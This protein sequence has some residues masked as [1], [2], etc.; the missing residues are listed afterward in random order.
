[1]DGK[2]TPQLTVWRKLHLE[3]DKMKKPEGDKRIASVVGSE[4]ASDSGGEE[5][6]TRVDVDVTLKRGEFAGGILRY[7]GT[8]Y[9]I[10][11]NQ[12][13]TVDILLADPA[14]I[15]VDAQPSSATLY[16]DDFTTTA[17]PLGTNAQRV[18]LKNATNPDADGVFTVQAFL[19]HIH[20]GEY[21]DSAPMLED[22]YKNGQ[23]RQIG[24]GES[25]F[26]IVSNA[27]N[28]TLTV[29]T[30]T[31]FTAS[32]HV[33]LYVKLGPDE[34]VTRV[35]PGQADRIYDMVQ[36][37]TDRAENRY[38]DAYL[39]PEWHA[40]DAFDTKATDASSFVAAANHFTGPEIPLL[41]GKDGSRNLESKLF[42]TIYTSTAYQAQTGEDGDG[43]GADGNNEGWTSGRTFGH[44]RS[45]VFMETLRDA[46]LD[47]TQKRAAGIPL[48]EFQARAMAH[49]IGHQ[50]LK[51]SVQEPGG[52]RDDPTKYPA[53]IMA[54][55]PL[56]IED[57]AF[58]L[59]PVDVAFI[60]LQSLI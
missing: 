40:L 1:M 36:E 39:Q 42:W 34:P 38:A 54:S 33:V 12:E 50:L 27:A 60:R 9:H 14:T 7:K 32:G 5:G 31:G 59:L 41:A 3:Q 37:T 35:D 23:I 24:F 2:L 22:E 43:L 30:T 11:D 45:L 52:H 16:Q 29:K 57:D 55:D 17:N 20:N 48:I 13:T 15:V 58:Y 25:L 47:F 18:F 21:E 10:V 53:N 19:P 49:E 51:G 8:N 28:G 44:A 4:E 56:I 6:L 26:E 46:F